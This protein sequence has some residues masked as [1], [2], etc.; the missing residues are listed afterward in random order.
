MGSLLWGA[1]WVSGVLKHG[2]CST[3]VSRGEEEQGG[4]KVCPGEGREE[5][6]SANRWKDGSL[7]CAAPHAPA[8]VSLQKVPKITINKRGRREGVMHS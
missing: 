3:M 7:L 5:G 2:G 4:K 6:D 1:L 8:R